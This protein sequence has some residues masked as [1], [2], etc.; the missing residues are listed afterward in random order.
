MS[1]GLIK[2]KFFIKLRII[3]FLKKND[4]L[5]FLYYF[6]S[7]FDERGGLD[8]GMMLCRSKIEIC[9]VS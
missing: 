8:I 3:L 2:R 5:F 1:W 4:D 6:L 7:L 9:D